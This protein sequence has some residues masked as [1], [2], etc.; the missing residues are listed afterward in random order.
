M[1]H[2]ISNTNFLNQNNL[3]DNLS[4]QI[5]NNVLQILNNNNSNF[6]NNNNPQNNSFQNINTNTN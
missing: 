2:N 6:Y 3:L 4:Q 1:K 5:T